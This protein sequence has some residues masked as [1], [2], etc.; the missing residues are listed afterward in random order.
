MI[1]N[2]K[3]FWLLP[4]F[5]LL[6]FSCAND[7]EDR[8]G[9]T[10]VVCTTGM[11]GDLVKNIGGDSIELITLM[12]PGVDPH[13]YK[14]TQG[15]LSKLRA[16]DLIVYNGLHLEGK[17]GEVLEQLAEVQNVF[18]IAR[19]VDSSNLL[20]DP[21]YPGAYDPHIWFDLSIWAS[22][23]DGLTK[24]L[25]RIKPEAEDYFL[26]NAVDYQI[27]LGEL[28]QWVFRKIRTIPP[29]KRKL[30]TA[31]DAFKYFG[32]AYG[33]EVK[34]LQGISTVSEFGL[35]DRVD[36]VNYIIE[37]KVPSI[38]VETSVSERNIRSVLE[39]CQKQGHE[40]ALGGSLYSDAMGEASSSAGSYVGM[41]E[42]NVNTI[43]SAL[44]PRLN[45][46]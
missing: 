8:N 6:L 9:K 22:T 20:A 1:K 34:G 16:A 24:E 30:I 14:A 19:A 38:F 17:M 40:V 18:P 26:E 36:L 32:K 39:A 25:I 2:L 31:H 11:I 15:D 43:V 37:H 10:T 27:R 45:E 42:A 46:N 3:L 7:T 12:G 4:L 44:K 35:K 29:S 23:I 13:L 5:S 21:A 41:V 28:N 33:V